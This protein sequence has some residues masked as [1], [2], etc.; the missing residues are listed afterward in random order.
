MTRADTTATAAFG[1]WQTH[2][3][4]GPALA[5]LLT[6]T[7]MGQFDF[8]VVNVAAPPLQRALHASDPALQLIVGG[9]AFA[10]AA[11]LITGGRLGDLYGH[12]R[13]YVAGMAA[14]TVSSL[15]CGAAQNSAELVAARLAEG[16]SVAAMLPQVL[17]LITATIPAA[18]RPRALGLYGIASGAGSIAGQVLGP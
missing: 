13:M 3:M 1:T 7:F 9:Y 6:A 2:G 14:F 8:F 12:R 15:A 11:G 17:A 10:Y 5:V 18:T 4:R 16:L